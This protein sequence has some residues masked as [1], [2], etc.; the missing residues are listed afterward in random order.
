MK[1]LTKCMYVHVV[2]ISNH[3][4]ISECLYMH[5]F[6]IHVYFAQKIGRTPLMAA[7]FHGSGNIVKLL[8]EAR[9]GVNTKDE[10]C[11]YILQKI[12]YTANQ[13]CVVLLYNPVIL[14]DLTMC[15][16]YRMGILLFTWQLR[17]DTLM[18]WD[19]CKKL[20]QM[21]TCKLRYIHVHKQCYLASL[22][23]MFFF[24]MEY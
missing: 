5:H 14:G 19:Y 20:M 21:S 15:S 18:W 24:L 22:Y 4:F 11:S 1:Y 9:A 2:I 16:L 6:F 17:K 13:H 12:H 8:I 3:V 7:A 10:V 23:G